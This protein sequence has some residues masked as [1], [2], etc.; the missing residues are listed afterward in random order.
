MIAIRN[1]LFALLV[2]LPSLTL[3]SQ[4]EV[5]HEQME[6]IYQEVKTPF[7]YGLVM[8]A[9]AQGQMADSPSIFRKGKWWYMYYIVFDGKGYE[10]WMARSRDLLHWETMGRALTSS[11][12]DD[13]DSSQKA[14]YLSLIDP[15]WGGSYKLNRYRGKYW[16]SY[17]GGNKKGYESGQLAAGM[18]FTKERPTLPTEWQRLPSPI[19]A[20]TDEDASWW[21]N[22]VIYKNTVWRDTKQQTGHPFFML[23][24][25]KG[26]AERIGMAVSDDMLHWKRYGQQPLLDHNR[27]ITGDAY[28]QRIGDVWVMFYFG[29][30]WSAE[31]SQK[32]WDTFAC[33]HD[34]IH[35][36]DWKGEPL[37]EPSEDYDAQYAHKP[38]VVKHKGI[39]YHFYCAVDKEGRRGIAVATSRDLGHSNLTFD[40]PAPSG[41]AAYWIAPDDSLCNQRNS[42]IEYRKEFRLPKRPKS[43]VVRMAA[44]SKY[45]LWVNGR[46]V[47][48]EGGLKRGPNPTDSYFDTFNLAPFLRKGENN[49]KVFLCYFGKDGFSHKNSGQAGFILDAPTLGISTD[50]TWLSQRLEAYQTCSGHEPN[51][52]LSESNIRYDARLSQQDN[53]QQSVEL[54]TWGDGLWGILVERPIPQWRVGDVTLTSFE[55]TEDENGNVVLTARLPYN[56][57]FTPFISLTDANGGTVV[58]IQTDHE[59]VGGVHCVRAEYVSRSG[60]QEYE[61]LGW[62]NGDF[63]YV[64]YPKTASF[65]VHSIGYRES[66][67][68]CTREGSFSCSD[69]LINRYW[70]KAMRTLYVNMRDNYFDCPERERA[71]WCGDATILMG[72]SFYQLSPKANTLARKFVRE[73]A[74]WQKAD[75]VLYSPTPAGNWFNELPAQSLATVGPKGFWYYYMHTGDTVTMRHVYPA[76]KKYLALWHLDD[77]GLTEMRSGGW[78]WGDWGDNIDLRLLLSEWHYMALQAAVDMARLTGHEEDVN[79]YEDQRQNIKNAFELSWNGT[80]YRHPSYSGDTDD[81][82]QAMAIVS[83]LAPTSRY[84]ALYQQ[85]R[86]HEHASPYMEKYVMEALFRMGYGEYALERFHRRFAPMITDSIH[87]TLYEN[88]TYSINS[89]GSVNHAWSGGMLNVLCEEMFGIRPTKAGWKEYVFAPRPLLKEASICIPSTAG[90]IVCSLK[91]EDE[92]ISSILTVPKGSEAVI[93]LSHL[94]HHYLIVNGKQLKTDHSPALKE[95]KYKIQFKL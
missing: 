43:A 91:M 2:L 32:A 88:W 86:E 26:N 80:A 89:G 66:G 60:R 68:G 65:K 21:D 17:L 64:S 37:V 15:T 27:G 29:F 9:P 46:L 33:S 83:G 72:Q 36:T 49:I 59:Q 39:V 40:T 53:L 77:T 18:A 31:T 10:T 75:S 90:E 92:I 38:C 81:R 20:P 22:S 82:V 87:T 1:I 45:W 23:Y 71:Q 94:P 93:D 8:T 79:L 62:M 11:S 58:G 4:T 48:F 85:L 30:N 74:D 57:Q 35:W 51:Y 70:E 5:S 63:L 78:S 67:F 69:T 52:R 44:D 14:G 47:I 54:A 12:P 13:W 61:S 95:G 56:M 34:L 16:M 7:K 6:A 84:V 19:L 3:K 41:L 24:N 76:V 73:F 28:L 42:W 25:A 55:Q 50:N